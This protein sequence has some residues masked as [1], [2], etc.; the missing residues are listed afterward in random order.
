MVRAFDRRGAVLA[1]FDQEVDDDLRAQRAVALA[2]RLAPFL[3]GAIV[4]LLAGIGVWQYLRH[5]TEQR[6]EAASA[7][8]FAADR[9]AQAASPG[10]VLDH[11]AAVRARDAFADVARQAPGGIAVLARLHV[12]GL[13]A[14]LGEPDAAHAEWARIEADAAAPA[15]QRGLATLLDC[16]SRIGTDPAPALNARLA[17]LE[18]PGAPWR[19]LAREAEALVDLASG[20]PAAARSLLTEISVSADAPQGAR[21]RAQGLLQTLPAPATS[22]NDNHTKNTTGG[23]AG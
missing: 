9:L 12:A 14:Q 13:D 6:A 10:G 15:A 8:Y 20:D 11:A 1:S 7:S 3:A 18:A 17:A 21:E 2:R 23:K 19:S 16:Q 4:L 22:S 5:R